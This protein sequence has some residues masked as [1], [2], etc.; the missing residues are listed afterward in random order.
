MYLK[1]SLEMHP[2]KVGQR[3]RREGAD[4]ATIKSGIEEATAKFQNLGNAF[5]QAKAAIERRG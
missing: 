4:D 3:L 1:K 2:D 5:D